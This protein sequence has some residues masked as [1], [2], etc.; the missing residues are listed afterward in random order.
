[1]RRRGAAVRIAGGIGITPIRALLEE[2]RGD[3]VVLYRVVS[4]AEVIFRSELEALA[5]GRGARLEIVEGDHTTPAGRMLLGSEHLR[6]LVPD[7]A[8]RDVF[9]CGPPAMT[10]AIERSVRGAGVPARQIR[11]ERFAL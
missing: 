10:A 11:A 8:A 1:P 2:M 4:D 6:R 7:I 9:V 3:L 5:R